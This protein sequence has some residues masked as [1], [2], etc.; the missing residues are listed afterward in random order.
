M[1]ASPRIARAA[2][3][4]L[5]ST[6]DKRTNLVNVARCAGWAK[7]DGAQMLFLPEC[8]GFMGDS[9]QH[10]LTEADPPIKELLL[11]K[12]DNFEITPFRKSLAD[13][14]SLC[15]A[16][17]GSGVDN[18]AVERAANNKRESHPIT[19]I[20]QELQYIA[21]ESKLWIS[22]GGVH[23]K[24]PPLEIDHDDADTMLD[25]RKIYN[26]H[27]IID[28]TGKI[29]AYYH[30]I[31]LFDVS[32]P[33]KVNLSESKTTSPGTELIVCNSPIGKLGLSICY[34][35]RFGEMYVDLV[36]KMGA[37]VLL[38]PS[39]FTVPTGK[40]H[41]HALLRA[42]AIEHQCYA[43]AAAQV[44]QHNEKRQSY[45]HS[46]VYDPWGELLADAGGYDGTGTSGNIFIT[47]EESPIGEEESSPVRV[48]SI[49]LADIDIDKLE[50]VRERMPYNN[51]GAIPTFLS[52][53]LV[54][55]KL[56]DEKNIVESW[57]SDDSG[58]KESTRQRNARRKNA[59]NI[60]SSK[61]AQNY[62][63]HQ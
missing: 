37:E 1:S 4:Q 28:D 18:E 22:G 11:L 59:V 8:L 16:G 44:G 55:E 24:V 19:S 9:A 10:T 43:L 40:A 29:Q 50:S 48:P 56:V 41:W 6:R 53:L 63:D 51:T 15:S 27:V 34:D 2:V 49:V 23:T 12:H 13:T 35:M 47:Q 32:I 26:T 21:N 36:Q 45:G 17:S 30:K 3:A 57:C 14:I 25:E 39:A 62:M 46:I 7:R 20:I 42:R 58:K 60:L 61:A 52:S 5:R 31:H 33:N 54:A 38:M